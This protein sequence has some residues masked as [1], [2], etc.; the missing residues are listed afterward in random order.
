MPIPF[1]VD[2]DMAHEDMHAILY[3]LKHPD[4]DVR[5]IAVAGTG[6]CHCEQGVAAA[7]HLLDLNS[8]ADDILVA[9]GRETPLACD[10]VFPDAWREQADTYYGLALPKSNRTPTPMDAADLIINICEDAPEPVII[11]AIG[12]LTNVA[13]ALQK[14]PHIIPNIRNIVIMGGAVDVKGNLWSTVDYLKDNT[15]A[16]WNIYIDPHA[17]D[18]V[19]RSGATVTLVPIDATRYAIVDEPFYDKLGAE[20]Q[21]PEADFV[22]R[23]LGANLRFVRSGHFQF[24]DSLTAAIALDDSLATITERGITVITEEGKESGYTK[25][26]PDGTLIRV[27]SWADGERFKTEFLG[28]LNA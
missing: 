22:H 23:M 27:A 14:A 9:C 3:L 26:D 21:T 1:I 6:E 12:P 10:H 4:A 2:T 18:I 17:A 28:R 20:K 25:P 19:V 15:V 8:A 24:W 11:V 13:V 7:L 5:A 16:E